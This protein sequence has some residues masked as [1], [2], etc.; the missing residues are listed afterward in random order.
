MVAVTK[1]KNVKTG[2]AVFRIVLGA[3]LIVIAFWVSGL[4][5]LVLGLIG[6][7]FLLTAFSGY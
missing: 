2:E 1:V 7:A 6:G 3:V 5:G 4:T